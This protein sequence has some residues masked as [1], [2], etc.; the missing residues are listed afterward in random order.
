ML[1]KQSND[2]IQRFIFPLFLS[3]KFT[4][5][6]I[7]IEQFKDYLPQNEKDLK[8]QLIWIRN[9]VSENTSVFERTNFD[10]DRIS[11]Y[12]ILKEIFA[13]DSTD[14]IKTITLQALILNLIAI[15]LKYY[16]N[17]N[18]QKTT[19]KELDILRI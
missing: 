10:L 18:N 1:K 11:I 4:V 17:R 9:E 12:L 5:V 3:L 19:Q 14:Y 8:R 15:Y 7:A 13:I 6:S 2:D 16:Q